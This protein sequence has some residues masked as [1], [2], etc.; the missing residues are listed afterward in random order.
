MFILGID[1]E[2][3]VQKT[4]RG[5]DNSPF[6]PDNYMVSCGAQFLGDTSGQYFFFKHDKKECDPSKARFELQNMLGMADILVGHNIKFDLLWLIE[7]GFEIECPVYCTMIGEYVLAR[8]QKVPLSLAETAKRREVT[9]KRSDLMEDTFKKGIGYEQ[10]DPEIVEVYG[11]GDVISCLEVYESQMHDYRKPEFTGLRKTRDMMNEMLLTL[12]DME[13]NGIYIDM[14]SLDSVEDEFT[15]ERN[16]LELRLKELVFTVMGDSPVNLNSPAQLSEVVYSRRIP[17]KNLW[18]ETFNVGLD[19]RGKPLPRPKMD[20]KELSR[21]IKNTSELIRRTKGAQC[22]ECHGYGTV[23]KIKKDGT[24]FKNR[25]KC[26]QCQGAGIVYTEL[27]KIA[28]FKLVPSSIRDVSANGFSTDKNTL[29]FLL[30]QAQR[31]G[32]DEAIEFLKGMRRLNALNVY[33]TS[34]C[35][36]IRRNT[37]SNGV[38]HT[39]YNQCIT[40]TGRLSSSD[41][42]FQNQPRGGTFPIRKCVVSRFEGGEIMEADFSGLEFR[43]AGALSKDAQIY[44]DIM[45][46]KDVHKQTAAIINQCEIDEVTK[47]MRQQAKAYTFAPL[48]GGQGG[49]E[50]T[51]VQTYFREYFNIYEGL[52]QWHERLKK[53]VLKHGTVTLP[54]GRQFY[55]PNVERKQGGRVTYATQIVNYPVQSFATADIVPLACIRVHKLMQTA[56]LKSLFVLTVHDSIVVDVHPDEKEIVKEI[57]IDGMENV[58]DELAVRY[59]YEMVIPLAIE[60]KSGSNWLNGNVIYE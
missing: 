37:R 3:T 23:Q 2:T 12:L 56:N 34:F 48:Y 19:K 7:S 21:S 22:Q 18:R 57:L 39:T 6:N 40:S 51:H 20:P 4:E 27:D 13:R 52:H 31:K 10:M 11:R 41:P 17:D 26:Q 5:Y 43:V 29:N 53:N 45:S 9:L 30:A 35:G 25:S 49:S 36:G 28:G 42:N 50:P 59:N 55:W 14:E 16:I 58:A 1:I 38:L 54:S 46:G 47:D 32:Y 15:K 44:E 33:L 24:P 8:G 60:I